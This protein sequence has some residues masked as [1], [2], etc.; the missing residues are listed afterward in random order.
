MSILQND[1]ERERL[2]PNEHKIEL[3]S[4]TLNDK[5]QMDAEVINSHEG[6]CVVEV[7]AIEFDWI[8]NKGQ[9]L[10]FLTVLSESKDI[11]LFGVDMI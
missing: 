10:K 5:M 8:F 4:K 1:A 6:Q 11:H 2:V 7:M 9:G 3:E